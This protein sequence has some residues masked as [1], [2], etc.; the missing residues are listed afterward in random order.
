MNW[1][2]VFDFANTYI[3]GPI[4]FIVSIATL[5]FSVRIKSEV[6]KAFIRRTLRED[7]P[8]YEKTIE[9][10]LNLL[11]FPNRY[12]TAIHQT[13][14]FVGKIKPLLRSKERKILGNLERLVT[15]VQP[16]TE[17]EQQEIVSS[18]KFQLSS[19]KTQLEQESHK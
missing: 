8:S 18:L 10:I 15:S 3:F 6:S 16:K 2:K 7:Y 17:E 1:L 9:E 12:D 11:Q 14:I 5:C 13:T 19:L 4:G